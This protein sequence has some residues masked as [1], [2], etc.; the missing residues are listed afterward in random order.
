[1][2]AIV[3]EGPNEHVSLIIKSCTISFD[4]LGSKDRIRDP[5]VL[6]PEPNNKPCEHSTQRSADVRAY[7]VSLY[8]VAVMAPPLRIV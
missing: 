5:A 1:M 3:E 8:G 6:S 7:Q 4:D 2:L